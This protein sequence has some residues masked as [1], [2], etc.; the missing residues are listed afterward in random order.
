MEFAIYS[1][2]LCSF[3]FCVIL[4]ELNPQT[5]FSDYNPDKSYCN[6]FRNNIRNLYERQRNNYQE[7]IPGVQK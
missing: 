3:S 1:Y 5:M 4:F 2:R 6:N 7:N